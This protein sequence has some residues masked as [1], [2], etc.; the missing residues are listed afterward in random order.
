MLEITISP[1]GG[2]YLD[3]VH[4]GSVVDAK[5][6]YPSLADAIQAAYEAW[7]A[8]HPDEEGGT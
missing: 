6:N 5:D 7:L 2:V 1:S 8:E 4:A 3:G